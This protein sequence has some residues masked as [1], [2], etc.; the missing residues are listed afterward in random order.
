MKALELRVLILSVGRVE[1]E[2]ILRG[3]VFMDPH[4]VK[5]AILD[6]TLS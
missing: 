5:R 6:S 3:T 2:A 4:K 1:A